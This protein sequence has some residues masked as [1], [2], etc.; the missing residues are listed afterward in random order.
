MVA[1]RCHFERSSH[2]VT[3]WS[4]CLARVYFCSLGVIRPCGSQPN[5]YAADPRENRRSSASLERSPTPAAHRLRCR[6]A[7]YGP[8]PEDHSAP[9]RGRSVCAIRF[10][11]VSSARMTIRPCRGSNA[12][13]TTRSRYPRAF[14]LY[15]RRKPFGTN[16]DRP[17]VDL[18][19]ILAMPS[20]R[21]TANFQ[22]PDATGRAQRALGKRENHLRNGRF[23]LIS[24]RGR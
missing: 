8:A 6:A 10:G 3:D 13:V 9:A 1:R 2:A 7:R 23:P 11:P 14:C 12:K 24:H 5:Q 15:R 20:Y 18:L 22:G 4:L 21:S 17:P 19:A 16:L